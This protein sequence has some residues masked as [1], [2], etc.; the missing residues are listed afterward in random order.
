MP[1]TSGLESSWKAT[2]RVERLLGPVPAK[3][4]SKFPARRIVRSRSLP[5]KLVARIHSNSALNVVAPK[6][7]AAS[8]SS[9]SPS[10]ARASP[11]K[12]LPPT[13][14]D[15]RPLSRE[16]VEKRVANLSGVRAALERSGLLA[17]IRGRD[18]GLAT[19]VDRSLEQ[20]MP[21]SVEGGPI[22]A[23][24]AQQL[25][26][27]AGHRRFQQVITTSERSAALLRRAAE[28]LS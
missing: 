13:T 12:A 27:E 15:A 24:P 20:A 28:T 25:T 26:S 4:L 8:R 1:T 22:P 5:L 10:P 7:R 18:A 17:M 19:S 11:A 21:I 23:S 14:K 16:V 6:A 2:S 9:R 3:L